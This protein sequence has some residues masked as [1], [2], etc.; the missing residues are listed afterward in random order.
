MTDET[1][2]AYPTAQS[3]QIVPMADRILVERLP[4]REQVR[5]IHVPD[6][7]KVKPVE[8]IVLATGRGRELEN[9]YILPNRVD[10]GDR[11]LYGLYAG[12]ELPEEYGKNLLFLRNDEVL[13][14]LAVVVTPELGRA[15][16]E[17]MSLTCEDEPEAAPV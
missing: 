15:A 5:G 17:T 11:I 9:G 14:V 10:V 16:M 2:P 13:A 6:A 3:Y 12:V 7:A 8:G 4:E 1:A